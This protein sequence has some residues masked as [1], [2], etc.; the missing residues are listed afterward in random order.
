MKLSLFGI[1]ALLTGETEAKFGFGKCSTPTVTQNLDWDQ[2]DGFWYETYTDWGNSVEWFWKCTTESY[3]QTDFN[4]N[5]YK[6]NT[7]FE[8]G[9]FSFT[10]AKNAQLYCGDTGDCRVNMLP[11]GSP[12]PE[13]KANYFVIDTDNDN[14]VIIY[15]CFHNYLAHMDNVWIMTREAHPSDDTKT[16]I[17]NALENSSISHFKFDSWNFRTVTHDDTCEYDPTY[18]S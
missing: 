8:I 5:I 16:L 3:E 12:D 9:W 10:W 7:P 6:I 13:K 1:A 18:V 11:F 14:F 2:F 15:S 4:E 17:T